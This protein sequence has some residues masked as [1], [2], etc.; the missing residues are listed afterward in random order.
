MIAYAKEEL[1][2]LP[3]QGY[4]NENY[5]FYKEDTPY[6]LRKFKLLGVDRKQE[7]QIQNIAAK[8]GLGAKA[9]YLDTSIMIGDFIEGSHHKKL[10]HRQ[11]RSLAL[12]LRKLHRI[13]FRKKPL[14]LKPKIQKRFKLDLVLSHHDLNAKNILF[15]KKG[16]K[17][18]DWEY[19]GLGDRY[20]DLATVCE[21]FDLDE[22]YF[23]RSYGTRICHDKLTAYKEI[24]HEVTK[25]WFIQLAKGKLPFAN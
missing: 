15:G 25:E 19:A 4:C 7:F 16:V 3:H 20:F 1:V 13:P 12:A 18:I 22:E 21:A 24:Y 10:T 6:H 5:L 14:L 2:L 17:F 9:H 8:R 23:L 11:T